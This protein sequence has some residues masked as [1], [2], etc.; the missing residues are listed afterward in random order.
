MPAA[1]HVSQAPELPH[2]RCLRWPGCTWARVTVLDIRLPRLQHLERS[3][4]GAQCLISNQA[5]PRDQES[6]R[7]GD[8]G[9]VDAGGPNPGLGVWR[10]K[11]SMDPGS[12]I[13]HLSVDQGGCVATAHDHPQQPHACGLR[14][15]SPPCGQH[16]RRGSGH[17]HCGT[18]HPTLPLHPG[19]RRQGLPAAAHASCALARGINIMEGKVTN[20][21]AAEAPGFPYFSRSTARLP[22]GFS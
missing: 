18:D 20:R 16:V 12:A 22:I 3:P 9:R 17:G 5:G 8:R 10:T 4:S 11:G 1:R 2:Q 14:C 21:S 19:C 13:V 6:S 15:G 7:P